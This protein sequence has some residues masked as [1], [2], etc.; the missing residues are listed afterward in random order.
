[1]Y[2]AA[3]RYEVAHR[4]GGEGLFLCF[5]CGVCTATCPVAEVDEDFNPRRIIH[6]VLLGDRSVLS[7]RSIWMCAACFRCVAHCPQGVEF[8]NVLQV[9]REMAVAEGHVPEEVRR[10]IEHLDART[11]KLR[12]DFIALLFERRAFSF[13]EYEDLWKRYLGGGTHGTS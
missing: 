3:F 11:Q 12:R 10:I 1:M 13:P 4:P 9:L 6:S 8:A 7:S 5:S 2:D